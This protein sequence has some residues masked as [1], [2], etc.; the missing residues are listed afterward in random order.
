VALIVSLAQGSINS[1]AIV[2]GYLD[3]AIF[4]ATKFENSKTAA[5]LAGKI[6][7]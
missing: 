7:N 5:F 4:C 3:F 6:H 1:S 2:F